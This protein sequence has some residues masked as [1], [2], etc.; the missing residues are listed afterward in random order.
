MNSATFLPYSVHNP[1]QSSFF[2]KEYVSGIFDCWNINIVLMYSDEN[3]M[4]LLIWQSL[5]ATDSL[6]DGNPG[7]ALSPDPL[8][9]W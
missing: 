4:T 3:D 9:L 2:C 7:Q 5:S 6:L 1:H 8:Q